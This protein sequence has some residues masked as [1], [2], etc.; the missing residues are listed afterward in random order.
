MQSHR[1]S[2]VFLLMVAAV[3]GG[4]TLAKISGKGAIPIMLNQ[5]QVKVEVIQQFK[6]SKM[7]AFDYT[8]AFDVSEVLAEHLIGSNA[9]A[10]MNVT[11]TVKTTAL[12]FLVNLATLGIAQSR[13][14]EV[15]GQVVRAPQGLSATD[16]PE[17]DVLVT[18]ADLDQLLER[19]AVSAHGGNGPY[20]IVRLQS[21]HGGT[22]YAL[23]QQY[24]AE[25]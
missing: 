20:T 14:F 7:R 17:A 8:G 16:F 10:L 13:T 15:S 11:I 5:P 21:D 25:Q 19:R 18:A 23:L 3:M 24:A 1:V 12:D 6:T 2:F 9:D 4:C 22:K